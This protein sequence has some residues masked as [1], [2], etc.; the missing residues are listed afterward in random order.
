MHQLDV[1]LI[2]FVT[3]K[4]SGKRSDRNST[5]FFSNLPLSEKHGEPK[6][7]V[8]IGNNNGLTR[9]SVRQIVSRISMKIKN[10]KEIVD[11]FDIFIDK[12]NSLCPVSIEYANKYFM[13]LGLI[14][15]PCIVSLVKIYQKA[16]L[17]NN[18]KVVPSLSAIENKASEEMVQCIQ[19]YTIK[20]VVHNGAVGMIELMDRFS[21]IVPDKS[22]MRSLLLNMENI[23]DL[24]GDYYYFGESGRNRLIHR[25]TSIFN[26]FK[27]VNIDDLRGAIERSWKSDINKEISQAHASSRTN[28]DFKT[29]TQIIPTEVI[30]S[31]L[32][33]VGIATINESVAVSSVHS[34]EDLKT[35][36]KSILDFIE[37][38]NGH[39]REKEIENYILSIDDSKRFACMQFISNSP[40]LINESR[41]L[42]KL[43]GKR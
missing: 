1:L 26:V 17:C 18:I 19:S 25:L 13:D 21:D 42:Y 28:A 39:A 10:S 6:T 22:V 27:S 34:Q 33:D 20:K 38:N 30:I 41:G 32:Q 16:M 9:E 7:L 29:F 36:D 11:L 2:D 3:K 35:I 5:I 4:V 8:E 14:Q 37:E 40:L 23:K 24:D 15:S 31:I 43:L 12:L